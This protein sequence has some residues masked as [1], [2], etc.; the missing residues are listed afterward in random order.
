MKLFA[1]VSFLLVMILFTQISLAQVQYYGI[2]TVLD[3]KGTSVVKL[4]IT[5][6]K[7]VDNFKLAVFGTIRNFQADSN[8]GPVNCNLEIGQASIISCPLNL[9]PEKR[10]LEMSFETDD[11]VRLLENRF[12]FNGDFGLNENISQV[13][14]SV[15]LPEGMAVVGKNIFPENPTMISDGRSIISIWKL[16]N[17]NKDQKLSFQIMYERTFL[18]LPRLRYFAVFGVA[19]AVILGLIIIR[20]IRKPEEV[21]LSV[22]DEFERKIMNIVVEAGGT[23][24]QKKI[25]Q[26][27]NLSKA[28]VSRV[29]K[30]L[31]ERGL[32]EVERRGRTN[33]IKQVK[34]KFKYF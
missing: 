34:K 11:F 17:V 2:D 13:F 30:S 14:A 20:Y 25:V 27:T 5:F 22:L 19:A 12:Y 10:T 1:T 9:T 8:A 16:D 3:N 31:S 23:V 18:I 15:K 26:E 24:N 28:K 33:I 29:V 21:V 4:T 7:P 6:S 32:V